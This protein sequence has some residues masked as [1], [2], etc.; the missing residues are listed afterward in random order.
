MPMIVEPATQSQLLAEIIR[1]S[2][3]SDI[4]WEIAG[5][6]VCVMA[7][8]VAVSAI[9]FHRSKERGDFTSSTGSFFGMIALC[10]GIAALA[11]VIGAIDSADRLEEYVWI[12]ET[13][14]GP[15]PESVPDYAEVVRCCISAPSMWMSR[16]GARAPRSSWQ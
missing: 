8:S 15:L 16:N 4:L 5:V 3:V 11:F 1:L 14:Y 10:M 13:V 2:G 7:A 12:Y 6:A 9:A